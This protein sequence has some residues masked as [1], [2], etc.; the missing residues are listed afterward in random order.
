MGKMTWPLIDVDSR[1]L[2]NASY[3]RCWF[4]HHVE[5]QLTEGGDGVELAGLLIMPTLGSRRHGSSDL[6]CRTAAAAGAKR[7]QR[8]LSGSKPLGGTGQVR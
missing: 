1:R 2:K 5:V 4:P 8:G 3:R 6:H 7:C